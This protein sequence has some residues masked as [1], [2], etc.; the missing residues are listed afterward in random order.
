M[1]NTPEPSDREEGAQD[2]RSLTVIDPAAMVAAEGQLR[3]ALLEPA[4]AALR[5][6]GGIAQIQGSKHYTIKALTSIAG[7]VGVSCDFRD[8]RTL[9][10]PTTGEAAYEIVCVA[11]RRD[12]VYQA[13]VG[14]CSMAE[15][16]YDRRSKA[17]VPRW[18]DFFACRSMAQT[19]AKVRALN[20]LLMPVILMAD[21]S[22]SG[23]PAEDMPARAPA[24]NSREAER[25]VGNRRTRQNKPPQDANVA[26]WV[27]PFGVAV[28]ES[29]VLKREDVRA[30][31]RAVDKKHVAGPEALRSF[32]G[33]EL[34]KIVQARNATNQV[35]AVPRFVEAIE[36]WAKNEE[37][38][39]EDPSITITEDGEIIDKETGES[40]EIPEDAADEPEHDPDC[41]GRD[42]CED[43]DGHPF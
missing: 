6:E 41:P 19:R 21:G 7:H 36:A 37:E 26:A 25:P 1:S 3:E 2:E 32:L 17:E 35:T 30:Y 38:D 14:F 22:L 42:E 11:T 23:T 9:E 28:G 8:G 29:E 24:E 15:T 13:A 27:E 31:A 18:S 34:S 4:R 43:P 12:G 40:L 5:M 39:P 20:A 33:G 16:R 10:D